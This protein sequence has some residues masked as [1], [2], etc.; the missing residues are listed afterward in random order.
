[1]D[2]FLKSLS[3]FGLGIVELWA[4]IPLGF[5]LQLNPLLTGT[6]SAAGAIVGVLAVVLLGKQ[7]RASLE[8]RR[9]TNP[10]KGRQGRLYRIWKRYGVI[11]LGLLAP[12]IT[13]APLGAVLGMALGA[14][15]NR[16][17]LWM[18]IGIVIWSAILT[19]AGVLG[20]TIIGWR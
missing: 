3:V 10:E 12:L 18:S 13:G 2:T 8:R 11:G 6:L 19:L 4:A 17:L 16:L 9:G 15:S 1:M 14:P 5:V 7:V 20:L